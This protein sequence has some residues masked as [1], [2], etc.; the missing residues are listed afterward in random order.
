MGTDPGCMPGN[1]WVIAIDEGIDFGEK[2]I[3][4]K[5]HLLPDANLLNAYVFQIFLQMPVGFT[6]AA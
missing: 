5:N 4:L 3:I 2:G 6:L 1:S